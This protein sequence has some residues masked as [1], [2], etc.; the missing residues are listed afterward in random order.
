MTT[1]LLLLSQLKEKDLLKT[2]EVRIF[3]LYRKIQKL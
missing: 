3:S 2:K 1:T